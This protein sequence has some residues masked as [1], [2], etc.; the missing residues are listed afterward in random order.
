MLV[1]EYLTQQEGVRYDHEQQKLSDA[2]PT[3]ELHCLCGWCLISYQQ[4]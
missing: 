4:P 1:L 2:K 3:K